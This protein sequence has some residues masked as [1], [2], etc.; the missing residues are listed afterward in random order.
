MAIAVATEQ[1]SLGTTRT[2]GG[3]RFRA[4]AP[5]GAELTLVIHDGAAPGA[6]TML[7]DEHG[8]FELTVEG[9]G[10]GDRYCYRINGG[11][12]R[13]DPASRFQPD[14]VHGPS[15]VIDPTSFAWTDGGWGGR[16][17][18]DLVLYELHVGTFSP[19]GTFAGAAA[20]LPVLRDAGVTA[21]ELMPVADFPGER[22]WGYDGVCL[23]APA[24]AYGEPD[25]LRRLVDRAHALGISV[26]L[27]VVYN[28]L[29]P[30]GAYLPEFY[31][32]YFTERHSTPWGRALNLDDEGAAIVRRFVIDN[33]KYWIREY[34]FDGLRLDA[35]HALVED[36]AGAIV[37][38][39]VQ[40]A[41]SASNRPVFIHAEDHR[42]LAAMIEDPA[43]GGW[44][45]DGVWADDFHHVMRRLL[46]G[47]EYSYYSDFEG[48]TEELARTIRQG[49]L[50]TGQPSAHLG[51]NRGTDPSRVPMRRFV[52][53][54]QNHDQIGNRALGDRLHS[55]ISAE[56]WRAASVILLSAP[57]TPLLFMG[58]EWA[59]DTPFQYFTDLEPGLGHLVTEG[60]RRE[61]ADFPEFSNAEARNR[62]PDPQSPATHADSHLDW[63]ELREPA[64]AAV[65][66]LYRALL[67]LR[68]DQ[69]ALGGSDLTAGDAEAPD[70][71]SIVIR[72]AEQGKVF[73]VVA[74]LTG[75]GPIDLSSFADARGDE[76]RDW[77]I[78]LST[79]EPLFALDPA[80]PQIDLQAGG[81][82]VHFLR[83][84]AIIFQKT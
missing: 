43:A 6:Y 47:D 38:E 71:G 32:A 82:V 33:A 59:A 3:T 18:N 29:G 20:R 7:P 45:V 15:Q 57:M 74:R 2:P 55:S 37:R 27:D 40:A 31:P 13:P 69:P 76:G 64:H 62:I 8:V 79:E 16:S 70:A 26:V 4:L 30:E 34:H 60:R 21:I 84:G 9:A 54:L 23:Y 58:Q 11:P 52:I 28:H 5:H 48:T 73:W 35:T 51:A 72:R 19:E 17:T 67:A 10:A 42:N 78:V 77:K 65:V 68:L 56:A 12:D 46:A 61:F 50:F 49:W 63:T 81:P 53:C 1:L 80:P 41:R 66:A 83:P 22:N 24:R 36:D 25:D 44:G 14:G 75:S 39:I